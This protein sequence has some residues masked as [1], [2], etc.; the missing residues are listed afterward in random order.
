MR[1]LGGNRE[2][3]AYVKDHRARLESLVHES[4]FYMRKGW[5]FNADY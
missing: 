1:S 2:Y 3:K 4:H 5:T